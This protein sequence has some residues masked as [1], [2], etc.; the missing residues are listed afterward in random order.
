MQFENDIPKHKKKKNRSAPQ[1]VN[2]K[3]NYIDVIG[4]V[5]TKNG[6]YHMPY[7][8]CT[9]CGK[10]KMGSLWFSSDFN[11][12]HYTR[13]INNIEEIQELNPDLKIVDVYW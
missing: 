5:H 11:I 9:E 3:H 1:K 2:H 12:P 6:V 4:R 7:S 10:L 13:I 8:Q